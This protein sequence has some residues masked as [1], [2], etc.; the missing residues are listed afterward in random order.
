LGTDVDSL[1][2]SVSTVRVLSSGPHSGLEFW[3]VGSRVLAAVQD[4][5]IG[6]VGVRRRG[7]CWEYRVSFG[8]RV[9]ADHV[10][11]QGQQTDETGWPVVIESLGRPPAIPPAVL[12]G[13]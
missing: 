4:P 11:K 5:E 3:R 2:L 9:P 12:Q 7:L 13:G 10:E 8:G 6:G 1:T